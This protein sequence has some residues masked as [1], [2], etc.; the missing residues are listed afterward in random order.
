MITIK[1]VAKAAGVAVSTASY[2]L[3]G[4][5]K[6][7]EKTREKVTKVAEEM[8]Y[9]PNSFA[10]NLKKSKADLIALIVHDI[11]GPFYDRLVKGIQDVAIMFGHNLIIFCEYNVGNEA[12]YNFLKENVVEGAIVLSSNLTDNEVIELAD[13]GYPLVLLDRQLKQSNVCSVVINNEKGACEAVNYLISLGHKKIGF[14]SG[15]VDSYDNACRM[16]GYVDTLKNN[17]IE[18]SEKYVVHGGFTEQSG[19]ETMK[20]YL[21]KTK[22]VPTA[23][24]S[25][26]DEMLIGAIKAIQEKGFKVPQDIS[27]I[28]FDDIQAA[29]YI[30]PKL[31]TIKGPMYELGSFSAHMLFNLMNGRAINSNL[32]LDIELVIRESAMKVNN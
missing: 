6:V 32:T 12:S 3:N 25:A 20:N 2:A 5:N 30:Q 31:T 13:N 28:G 9:V 27:V 7:S 10:R 22:D 26:N 15:P 21:E 18:V 19:Y 11:N 23:F 17:S 14:I 4:S 24:F 1:D 16:K 29:N 8:K